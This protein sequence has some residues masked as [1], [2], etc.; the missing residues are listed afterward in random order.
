MGTWTERRRYPRRRLQYAAKIDLRDGGALQ[1]CIL[2][3]ISDT[4][5]R[6]LVLTEELPD[7]FDLLL[8]QLNR[9][10]CNVIWRNGQEIGVKFT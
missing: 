5:A 4:G 2:R 1:A 8:S 6:M 10:R 7:Q 9:R 3:D